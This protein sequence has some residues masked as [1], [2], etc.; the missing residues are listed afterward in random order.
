MLPNQLIDWRIR[1]NL[2]TRAAAEALGCSR[3]SINSWESGTA[4]I[5]R[6]IGIAC[7]GIEMNITDYI[8][9]KAKP[10]KRKEPGK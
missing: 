5:P 10:R 4:R 6:Y 7:T 3:T 9:P 8:P 1:L 2:T